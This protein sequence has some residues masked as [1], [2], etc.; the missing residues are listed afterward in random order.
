LSRLPDI[1][2]GFGRFPE[3]FFGELRFPLRPIRRFFRHELARDLG[4]LDTVYSPRL[5]LSSI[6]QP[7][8]DCLGVLPFSF[9]AGGDL[10][11]FLDPLQSSL[12]PL[13]GDRDIR[14][15]VTVGEAVVVEVGDSHLSVIVHPVEVIPMNH[16]CVAEVAAA[17]VIDL[18]AVP[19]IH[20]DAVRPPVAM[21]IVGLE[22]GQRHP[23]HMMG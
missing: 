15:M 12:V 19:M 1:G 7:F 11:V 22:G 9:P 2:F 17:P 18:G 13:L 5:I 23:S 20:D 16:H 14:E 8:P 10:L 6:S 3:G 4:S 21:A